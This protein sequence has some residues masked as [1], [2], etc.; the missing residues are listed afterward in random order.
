[1]FGQTKHAGAVAMNHLTP[2]IVMGAPANPAE[3][4]FAAGRILTRHK[5]NPCRKL[6]SRAKM[7]TV[8]NRSDERWGDH[9]PDARQLRESPAGFVRPA[10]AKELPVELIESE[11]EG[12]EFFEQVA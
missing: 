1:M 12:A 8:V 3:P 9:G 4:R 7:V 11:I 2:E 10:N 6:P 5:A